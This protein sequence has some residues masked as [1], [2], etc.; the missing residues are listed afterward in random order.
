[1]PAFMLREALKSTPGCGLKAWSL[2]TVLLV[3]TNQFSKRTFISGPSWQMSVLRTVI[4]G[5]RLHDVL[6]V[7]AAH[8]HQSWAAWRRRAAGHGW[9][10]PRPART[11]GLRTAPPGLRLATSRRSCS[12]G[13]RGCVAARRTTSARPASGCVGQG[14][15]NPVVKSLS[16]L[17]YLAYLSLHSQTPGMQAVRHV[18]RLWKPESE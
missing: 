16:V 7:Q 17:A 15:R 13:A 5:F 18:N 11:P 2:L 8:R 14:P 10:P 6:L 9:P 1:M 3:Q 12:R 4:S